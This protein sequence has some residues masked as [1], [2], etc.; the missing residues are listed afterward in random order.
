[1]TI[2]IGRIKTGQLCA[3]ASDYRPWG[4]T[5]LPDVVDVYD[6]DRWAERL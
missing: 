1:V 6:A 4:G 3:Y 2:W 5:D